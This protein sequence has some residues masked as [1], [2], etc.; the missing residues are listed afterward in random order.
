MPVCFI[1]GHSMSWGKAIKDLLTKCYSSG[2]PS[3]AVGPIDPTLNSTYTFLQSF[4]QEIATVFPD[5][6]VHLGG[7]EVSFTCWYDTIFLVQV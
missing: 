6:Y 2:Q 7:D 3:G 5:Q 1:L 4:F